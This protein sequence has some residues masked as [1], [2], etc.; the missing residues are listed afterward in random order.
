MLK[1]T[2]K[3]AMGAYPNTCMQ[4]LGTQTQLKLLFDG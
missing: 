1:Q 3:G 4:E 2:S